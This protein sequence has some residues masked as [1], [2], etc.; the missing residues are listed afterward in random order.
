MENTPRPTITIPVYNINANNN[1]HKPLIALTNEDQLYLNIW[2]EKA[3]KLY[4]KYNSICTE[5]HEKYLVDPDPFE[6]KWFIF[7]IKP[8]SRHA[9]QPSP[10]LS[11]ISFK[12]NDDLDFINQDLIDKFTLN[13]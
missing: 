8:K 2:R 12:S 5:M 10:C 6:C 4:K 1:T 13:P 11:V 3:R 7:Y 9:T